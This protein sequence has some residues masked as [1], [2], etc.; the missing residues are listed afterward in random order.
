MCWLSWY[1]TFLISSRMSVHRT[2]FMDS[3][4]SVRLLSHASC[5]DSSLIV[6][7]LIGG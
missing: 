7:C 4:S 2:S 5:A 6:M 3:P 1:E